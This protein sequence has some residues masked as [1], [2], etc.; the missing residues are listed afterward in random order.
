MVWTTPKF[1]ELST[2]PSIS[3]LIVCI[4]LGIKFSKLI[5][6]VF[7]LSSNTLSTVVSV[8]S[9]F[10]PGSEVLNSCL[11]VFIISFIQFLVFSTSFLCT[12][13]IASHSRGIA[14]F[15]EPPWI[16]AKS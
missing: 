13:I 16:L 6:F 3:I 9:I 7:V 2:R 15:L 14:L 10:M 1:V 11:N 4:P 8:H 12:T 5:T